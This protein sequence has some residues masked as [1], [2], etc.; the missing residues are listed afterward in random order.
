LA[1]AIEQKKQELAKL[2]QEMFGF[3]DKIDFAKFE[4]NQQKYITK[5]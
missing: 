1:E 2:R 5:N 4:K 3:T